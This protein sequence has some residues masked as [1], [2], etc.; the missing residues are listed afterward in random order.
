MAHHKRQR[1]ERNT[2][3]DARKATYGATQTQRPL[4]LLQ[5]KTSCLKTDDGQKKEADEKSENVLAD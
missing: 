1:N 4:I 5:T 2:S 3:G